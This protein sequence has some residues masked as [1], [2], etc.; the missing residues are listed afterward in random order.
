MALNAVSTQL[1]D[2]A[3]HPECVIEHPS[4]TT[5]GFNGSKKE[6]S[7]LA[8]L[9]DVNTLDAAAAIQEVLSVSKRIECA[10]VFAGTRNGSRLK[11]HAR[12]NLTTLI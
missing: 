1:T 9:S 6:T 11:R 5:Q 7:V 10:L 2:Q 12:V 8:I 4:S 3:G